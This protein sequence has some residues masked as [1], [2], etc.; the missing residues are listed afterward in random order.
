[1]S[2]FLVATICFGILLLWIIACRSPKEI[3]AYRVLL[4]VFVLFDTA[5]A[6]CYVLL[7]PVKIRFKTICIIKYDNWGVG[8]N[9]WRILLF[10]NNN[11]REVNIHCFLL[12]ITFYLLMV[13][14]T[15]LRVSSEC[16]CSSSFPFRLPIFYPQTV[17]Y[18]RRS[19]L[20]KGSISVRSIYSFFKQRT[21]FSVSH[22]AFYWKLLFGDWDSIA[23]R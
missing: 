14:H 10:L 22:S 3:G 20:K 12:V 23:R 18:A 11:S 5:Y 1:M 15:I 13:D 7:Y 9:E 6:T 21:V 2:L 17:C 4:F 16:V 8:N 19:I